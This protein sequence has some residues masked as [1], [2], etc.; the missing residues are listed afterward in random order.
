[1]NSAEAQDVIDF[2]YGSSGVSDILF[3]PLNIWDCEHL[4]QYIMIASK[5]VC[6]FRAF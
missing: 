4:S 2:S 5:L 3:I 6:L 1:M